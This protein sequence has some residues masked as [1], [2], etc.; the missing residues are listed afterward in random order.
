MSFW[1]EIGLGLRN[2]D[3]VSPQEQVAK[4]TG[5]QASSVQCAPAQGYSQPLSVLVRGEEAEM[6]ENTLGTGLRPGPPQ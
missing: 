2:S 3:G 4:A 6:E 5:L 1:K